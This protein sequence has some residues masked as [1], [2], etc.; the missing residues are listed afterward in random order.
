MN[1]VDARGK[2]GEEGAF[3]HRAVA[4]SNN[5]QRLVAKAGQ[6][7]VADGTGRD[8]S[9]LEAVFALQAQ[10]IGSCP[11]GDD[12]RECLDLVAVSGCELEGVLGEVGGDDVVGGDRRAKIDRLL[13]HQLHQ[14]G[15]TDA[16]AE[17]RR[18]VATFVVS[19]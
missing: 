7:T 9:I 12:Q 18:H 15:A 10:V 8:A 16:F 6:G 17:V 5:N 1:D 19:D 11:G 13:L 2:L 14:F 3:F 4:A